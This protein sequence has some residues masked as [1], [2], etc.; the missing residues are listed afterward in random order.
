ME[1]SKEIYQ[2][3]WEAALPYQ[4]KRD[5]AGHA[6][7]VTKFSVKLCEL[8]KANGD[9]VIP[10]AILHDIGWSRLSREEI[11]IGLG[12]DTA[13]DRMH[14]IRLK[15]QRESVDLG[16]KILEEIG[17]PP[18]L[19]EKIIEIISQHD[20]REGFFSKEDGCMRDADKLW[21]FSQEGFEADIRR[22]KR[23]FQEHYAHNEKKINRPGYFFSESA[24]EIAKQEIAE[25]LEE[26]Q[27]KMRNINEIN[28][29]IK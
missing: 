5:D 19:M 2:I 7:I 27:M 14:E 18:E 26:N 29:P 8:E 10:A 1:F 21:Q 25:R 13:K 9:V 11:Q 3:I 12:V 4:D 22:K 20:T 17:Y 28:I 23:T 16:R 24:R 6:E 15:H